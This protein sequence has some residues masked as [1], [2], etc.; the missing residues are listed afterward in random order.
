MSD[1]NRNSWITSKEILYRTGISRAT[2]NNYIKMQLIP[3]PLVQKPKEGMEGT[4]KIG[5]F[6]FSTLERIEL[7]KRL[8]QGGHSMESICAQLSG[9]DVNDF[10]WEVIQEQTR[11]SEPGES[12]KWSDCSLGDVLQLSFDEVYFPAYLINYNFEIIWL[13]NMAEERIFRQPVNHITPIQDRNIFKLFFHW[14]FHSY[15]KNWKD[16][17]KFHVSFAKMKYARSWMEKLYAGISKIEIALLQEL[18][19]K[20]K[21]FPKTII[22]MTPMNLLLSEGS[23]ETYCIYSLFSKEGI[24]YLYIQDHIYKGKSNIY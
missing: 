6:P 17:I 9:T 23:T 19:D 8:K 20:V 15:V 5:Y 3:K 22:E 12:T 10:G 21:V 16:L 4:K 24:F 1:Y 11:V 13:N 2:L 18:Y 14:E 7:I